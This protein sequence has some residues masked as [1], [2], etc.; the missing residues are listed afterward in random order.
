MKIVENVIPEEQIMK[1]IVMN[2]LKDIESIPKM[3]QKMQLI[4]VL[5]N[6]I[7]IIISTHMIYI[8]VPQGNHVHLNNDFLSLKKENV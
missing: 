4:I 2:V 1:I 6:V 8:H 3:I 5:Y 7:I